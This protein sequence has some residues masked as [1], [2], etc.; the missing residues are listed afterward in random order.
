MVETSS[1][2]PA[3][4]DD[5]GLEGII[6]HKKAKVAE[7]RARGVNPYPSRSVR[8]HDAAK[9]QTMAAAL[10]ETAPHS[11]EKLSI[12]GRLVELRDMGKSIF[13]R[14]A[15]HT[16]RA[17]VYFKKDAL[18]E[19]AFT[20]IKRD[21]AVGDYLAVSGSVFR[22]KTGELTIAADSVTMLAKALRPL[23]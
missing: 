1:A 2:S 8:L 4:D 7:M 14:L 11:A 17:Q 16:G 10:S 3:P 19:E 5:G 21:S 12:A 18:S 22:T 6:A 20:I 23:P 15:D 9:V 13:G